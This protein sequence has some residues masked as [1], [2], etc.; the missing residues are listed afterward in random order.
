MILRRYL[1]RQVFVTTALVVGFLVVMLLGG[2]LIRY[3][4]MAAEGGLQ[5]E[6]LF[7]LIGY[8]VPFLLELILPVSFFIALM[9]VFGRLYADSEMSAITAGG[10][11]RNRLGVLLVPL[12]CVLFVLEAYLSLVG[13]PWGVRSSENIWQEQALSQIFDLVRPKEFISTGNYHFYVGDIGDNR[14]FLSDVVI[15]ETGDDKDT[16]ILASRAT[17]AATDNDKLQLDLHQGKRYEISTASKS[18]NEIGF[19][20]YR[21]TLESKAPALQPAKIETQTLSALF[22]MD[23]LEAKA[24][25]GYRFSLPFL[26]VL[27]VL[28]A[29]PLSTVKPRQGRWLKLVPAIFVFVAVA[30]ILIS[31]KNPIEKGKLSLWAYPVAVVV[32]TAIALYMNQHARVMA[33]LR[34]RTSQ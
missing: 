26:M 10:T 29:L 6:F 2:R 21:M 19:D 4:G 33:R 20:T 12:I 25:L 23:S 27:A 14:E 11:S 32:L 16:L 15:I 7:R 17:Q 3:F 13:K 5:V 28:F 1:T 18:Y 8:N 22:K 31:L 30:L 24:E 34:G 9:L